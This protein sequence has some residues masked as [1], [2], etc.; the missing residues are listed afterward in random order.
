MLMYPVRW[1]SWFVCDVVMM[2]GG[3][4][5]YIYQ[6]VLYVSIR[7]SGLG[8]VLRDL[9][10]FYSISIWQVEHERKLQISSKKRPFPECTVV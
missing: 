2:L 8:L 3:M 1:R 4:S 6:G 5:M 10:V 9:R 7:E